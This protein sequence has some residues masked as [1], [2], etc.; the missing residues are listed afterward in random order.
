MLHPLIQLVLFGM[1][2]Y[3]DIYFCLI[4]DELINGYKMKTQQVLAQLIAHDKGVFDIAFS[5]E[6]QHVFTSAGED[7]SVRMFDLRYCLISF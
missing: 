6:Q 4:F 2:L 7:G 5:S 3:V 1:F